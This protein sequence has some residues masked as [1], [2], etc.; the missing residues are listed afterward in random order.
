MEPALIIVAFTLPLFK[1][2]YDLVNNTKTKIGH[3]ENISLLV[4]ISFVGFFIYPSCIIG[5]I[6]SRYKLTP[7]SSYHDPNIPVDI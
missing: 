5:V 4:S 6:R 3:L 7:I 2:L 1:K